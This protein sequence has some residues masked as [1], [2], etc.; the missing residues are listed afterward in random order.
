MLRTGA[1][2]WSQTDRQTDGRDER[3]TQAQLGPCRADVSESQ[4]SAPS[5]TTPALVP[6]SHP[7]EEPASV[8]VQLKQLCG[9]K[10]KRSLSYAK[11]VSSRAMKVRFPKHSHTQ[12]HQQRGNQTLIYIKF[13]FRLTR[14]LSSPSAICLVRTLLAGLS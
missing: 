1:P 4:I 11:S 12:I 7:G 6:F 3:R 13:V 14:R 8:V 10:I 2:P 5:S 9:L